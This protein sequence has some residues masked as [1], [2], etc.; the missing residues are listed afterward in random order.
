ME[1]RKDDCATCNTN[2]KLSFNLCCLL[3]CK[4]DKYCKDCDKFNV[5]CMPL[6]IQKRIIIERG[7]K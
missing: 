1:D 5:S 4:E 3:E 6:C 7:E 2:N